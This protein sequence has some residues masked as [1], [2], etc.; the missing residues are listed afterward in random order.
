[1]SKITDLTKQAPRSPRQRIG[2]YVVLARALDKGRA[3]VHGH[4]GDY[5][6]DCPLDNMLFSFKDV[7]GVQIK[8]LLE[9][10]R[11]DE[12]IVEWLDKHGAEK[13]PEEVKQWASGLE[14]AR[15]YEN[16]ER[17]EWFA[18]ECAKLGLDPANTTLFDWLEADDKASFPK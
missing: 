17:K 10:G 14:A 4:G 6:F 3:M 1:M 5:H 9:E 7:K 12:Q 16:P 11:S 18:G 2:N 15:P 13:T 8:E